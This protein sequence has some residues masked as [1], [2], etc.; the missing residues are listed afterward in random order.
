M[1]LKTTVNVNGGDLRKLTDSRSDVRQWSWGM[2][3][4]G[5]D[6]PYIQWYHYKE[7]T[8]E[9]TYKW[10]GLTKGAAEGAVDDHNQDE[11]ED[12]TWEGNQISEVA[13]YECSIDN[14]VI[15]SYTLTKTITSIT[16]ETKRVKEYI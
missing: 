9:K 3:K 2:S 10:W 4:L 5:A 11:C 14:R 16:L 7:T 1:A 13:S 8:T 12:Y 15:G 6:D